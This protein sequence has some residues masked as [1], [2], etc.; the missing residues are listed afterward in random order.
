LDAHIEEAGE[1]GSAPS[2]APAPEAA[3]TGRRDAATK[4]GIGGGI[5]DIE[6]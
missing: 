2:P 6:R 1:G 5:H 3:S 4:P